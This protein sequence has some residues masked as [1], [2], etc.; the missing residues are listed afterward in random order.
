MPGCAGE[1]DAL[2]T[3]RRDLALAVVTA[4]CVP[5]LIAAESPGAEPALAAVHA[6]WRGVASRIAPAAVERLGAR[7]GAMAAWIGPAIGGCCYE[8]GEDVARRVAAGAGA[9]GGFA[10]PGPRGRPHVDLAAAVESQ[11]RAAGVG[12]IRRVD[13]CTRCDPDLWS[14]RREGRAAGRNL[15]II[16][17][18]P[19]SAAAC[20]EA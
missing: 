20:G 13:R 16:Y 15:A 11:L 4:D 1:A 5:V 6:G 10:R 8:V 12:R 3:R 7:P 14:Y 9:E 19:T 17:P 2:A 18:L